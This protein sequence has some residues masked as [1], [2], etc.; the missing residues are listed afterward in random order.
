MSTSE[1]LFEALT[2]DF[3]L[4]S[5]LREKLAWDENSFNHAKADLLSQGR[6]KTGPGRGGSLRRLRDGEAPQ[7]ARPIRSPKVAVAKVSTPVENRRESARLD[8][9]W[10]ASTFD[11]VQ[12][13]FARHGLMK[14]AKPGRR[15]KLDSSLPSDPAERILALIGGK[16]GRLGESKLLR[17]SGLNAE[18]L[19]NAVQALAEQGKIVVKNDQKGSY[20]VGLKIAK[21]AKAPKAVKIKARKAAKSPKSS[22]VAVLPEGADDATIIFANLP[23]HGTI[24]NL[25]LARRL[26]WDAGRYVAAKQVLIDSGRAV[27]GRG[28]GGSLSRHDGISKAAKVKTPKAAKIKAP[29]A[30]KLGKKAILPEG[31]ND[32][33]TLFANL[34]ETAPLGNGK[35]QSLLSWD[36]ARYAAARQALIVSGRALSGKGRGGSLRPGNGQ[37]VAAKR[38]KAPSALRGSKP[39]KVKIRIEVSDEQLESFLSHLPENGFPIKTDVVAHKMGIKRS[40]CSA[41]AE[42]ALSMSLISRSKGRNANLSRRL[43]RTVAAPLTESVKAAVVEIPSSGP[44]ASKRSDVEAKHNIL[45]FLTSAE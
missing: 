17:R 1:K 31:A 25:D 37:P 9:G 23:A 39:A 15:P 35:L 4:T 33:D 28:R 5:K 2:F 21:A 36:D 45:D 11:K 10:D 26:G 40:V 41:I 20:R 16:K 8:L 3:S 29:K 32:A 12:A 27:N 18:M 7:P 22:K 13:V 19:K 44:T 38:V 43:K 30:A 24:G 42:H 6:V 14:A 34:S